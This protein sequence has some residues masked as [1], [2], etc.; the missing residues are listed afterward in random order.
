MSEPARA[1]RPYLGPGGQHQ[2]IKWLGATKVRILLDADTTGGQVS[3]VEEF[4]GQGD[5][6]PLHVHRYEDEMF[7]L[8]EGAMTA[9]VGEQRFEL[10]TGGITFLPRLIPHAYRFTAERS[11]ALLLT[12]PAGIEDMFREVGWDLAKPLPDGWTVSMDLLKQVSDRRGTPIVGP[13]PTL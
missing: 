3:V 2:E 8:L 5:G 11:R 13:P 7:W 10:S 4:C 9:W 6:P 12:T 1:L